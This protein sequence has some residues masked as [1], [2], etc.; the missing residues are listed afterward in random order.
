MHILKA[1]DDK[2][3]RL[4]V[5][6]HEMWK[7]I[8][9]GRSVKFHNLA[10]E[11]FGSKEI[12]KV[13]GKTFIAL[14]KKVAVKP[15]NVDYIFNQASVRR[16]R[17]LENRCRFLLKFGNELILTMGN[18]NQSN[19]TKLSWTDIVGDRGWVLSIGQ[20]EE[21]DFTGKL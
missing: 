9:R 12:R 17:N 18:C 4:F 15:E 21:C 7:P 3:D 14:A 20:V 19:R 2:M 8:G 13:E 16:D 6:P 10:D 1:S 5:L 11:I